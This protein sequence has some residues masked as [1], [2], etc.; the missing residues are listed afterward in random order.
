[1]RPGWDETCKTTVSAMLADKATMGA[2]GKSVRLSEQAVRAGIRR[3][4]LAPPPADNWWS[5]EGRHDL[6][7]KLYSENVPYPDVAKQ[8][9]CSV[10]KVKSKVARLKLPARSM[11]G[12]VAPVVAK[13]APVQKP[14]IKPPT[15]SP[16]VIIYGHGI[17]LTKAGAWACKWPSDLTVE[18]VDDS[19]CC[20][21][22]VRRPKPSEPPPPYCPGHMAVAYQARK[23]RRV[24]TAT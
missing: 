11:R 24:R 14:V 20:G 5:L 22:L 1:M 3:Y 2:I 4:K 13:V 18:G 10:T 16:F 21:A 17:P 19:I 6:L 9:G 8:L 12:K 23:P 15:I 7:M